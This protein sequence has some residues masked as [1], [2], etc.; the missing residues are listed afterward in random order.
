MKV[1][2]SSWQDSLAGFSFIQDTVVT[3]PPVQAPFQLLQ[4]SVALSGN[5]AL[6]K[7]SAL[8]EK[9]ILYYE[10]ER[11][12]DSTEFNV[13][14]RISPNVKDAGTHNYAFTDTLPLPGISYY[15]IRMVDTSNS[16]TYSHTIALQIAV[17]IAV[18]LAMYPNPVKYGFT[19]V[20]LPATGRPSRFEALD[21]SGKVI[22]TQNVSANTIQVRVDLSGVI[23]G[24][25]KLIWSDGV[26]YSWQT[27]VV[28]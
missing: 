2:S 27:I 22:K 1:T 18:R 23:R 13:L 3:P 25:Y 26:N 6:L 5:Q 11:G 19:Y 15:R 4:F 12:T 28:L 8:N 7:W 14:T 20:A 24:T 17:K 21:M 10:V 9:S 16:F